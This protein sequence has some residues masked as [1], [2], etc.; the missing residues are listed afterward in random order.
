[1]YGMK[2]FA[3]LAV[4]LTSAGFVIGVLASDRVVLG[5][6]VGGIVLLAFAF[7]LL[8]AYRMDAAA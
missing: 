8:A 5:G 1:M 2:T 3:A 6:W 7:I 4:A